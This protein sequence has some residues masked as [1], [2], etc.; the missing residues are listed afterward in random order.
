[1]RIVGISSAKPLFVGCTFLIAAAV[2]G[3]GGPNASDPIS[4]CKATVSSV[5][6]RSFQ[7]FPTESQQFY[8]SLA[9]CNAGLSA[10]ICTAALTTCSAGLKFDSGAASRC[11]EDY[12]NVACGDI[13]NSIAPASCNETCR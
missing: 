9:D 11:V 8:G 1:M 3:C 4:A 2:S 7:C 10:N 13:L 12:K 6:E 5:C